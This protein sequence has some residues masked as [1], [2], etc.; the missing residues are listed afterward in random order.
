MPWIYV[1]PIALRYGLT[2]LAL[3]LTMFSIWYC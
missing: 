2:C 1:N 3:V